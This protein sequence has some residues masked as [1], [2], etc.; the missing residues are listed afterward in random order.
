MNQIL[1][2]S[3]NSFL[4]EINANRVGATHPIA[5]KQIQCAHSQFRIPA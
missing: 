1:G 5:R 4:T 2:T 3:C